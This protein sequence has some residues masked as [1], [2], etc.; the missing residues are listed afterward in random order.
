MRFISVVRTAVLVTRNWRT[1]AAFPT[2]A[3]FRV[4]LLSGLLVALSTSATA[5]TVRWD[6]DRDNNW[7]AAD[8]WAPDGVPGPTDDVVF[9]DA[10]AFGIGSVTLGFGVGTI[11][12]LSLTVGG[13]G[14]FDGN[15]TVVS[16]VTSAAGV[17]GVNTLGGFGDV[18]N[19][20]SV[21]IQSGV[22]RLS[23]ASVFTTMTVGS[24]AVSNSRATLVLAGGASASTGFITTRG[25]II[26]VDGADSELSIGGGQAESFGGGE[27]IVRNLGILRCTNNP[28]TFLATGFNTLR[29]RIG[30]GSVPGRIDCPALIMNREG[31]ALAEVVLDHNTDGLQL[32]RPNGMPIVLGGSMQLTA[33]A[34][35]RTIIRGT[36]T[37]T[38]ATQ[39]TDGSS[40]ELDG[41][42]TASS[43]T[44]AGGSAL[45]GRGRIGGILIVNNG[46]SVAPGPGTTAGIGTL[47]V[48]SLNAASGSTLR[49]NLG[50]P[51][52]A[53]GAAND[54]MQIDGAATI[55]GDVRIDTLGA[56]GSYPLF[57]LSAAA[58]LPLPALVSLPAGISPALWQLLSSATRID[59]SPRGT[60][61]WQ[62]ATLNFVATEGTTS[63]ASAS[64]SNSGAGRID[65]AAINSPADP[66]FVRSGGS[67]PNTAFSLDAGATACTVG[68]RFEPNQPG[69]FTA[70]VNVSSNAISPAASLGLS[71]TAAQRL[72]TASPAVVDFGAVVIATA[73]TPR[74]VTVANSSAAATS[75]TVGALTG[76]FSVAATTCGTSLP[77][78]GTC[79][80]TLGF[81]PPTAAA[82]TG[83]LRVA[84]G[85][86]ILTVNL[87]GVGV[88][89]QLFSNGFEP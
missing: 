19:G 44:V 38:G 70:T 32:Q 6:G 53:G 60:V 3:R 71:G 42:L 22:L 67:C 83:E 28:T 1:A 54:L 30:E 48:G 29:L 27:L 49:F 55:A 25:G 77:S 37:Y 47:R 24:G 26:V 64:L 84:T 36:H 14:I 35:G 69:A 9:D 13:V 20:N 18:V 23:G 8:N 66:R 58:Q 45:R 40:I 85:A 51:G 82:A 46:A 59:L 79:Q 68:Y 39:I 15:L 31:V 78:G 62:P 61:Q 41:E 43:T 11:N 63:I 74:V 81:T 56:A 21:A 80:I 12:S 17:S 89:V 72:A 5:A 76:A 7:F 16:T 4:C 86:G 88:T 2:G 52:I 87:A 75:I 10:G 65:I 73:A 33:R 34:G 50:T 57:V